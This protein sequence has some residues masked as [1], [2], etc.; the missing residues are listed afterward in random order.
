MT[1]VI[2]PTNPA[3]VVGPGLT[4]RL[5]TSLPGPLP[6]TTLWTV[7]MNTSGGS[8]GGV[9]L[10]SWTNPSTTIDWSLYIPQ[11]TK[12][13]APRI[14]VP[15]ADEIPISVN[16]NVQEGG[17]GPA[18]DTGTVDIP[19]S[20][21][22][23]VPNLIEH[24]AGAD[25]TPEEQAQLARADDQTNATFQNSAGQQT[26]VPVS[27]LVHIP[28]LQQLVI[29]ATTHDLI[30]SGSLLVP[31][32]GGIALAY[33][34]Q[35]V[36]TGVPAGIGRFVGFV[37]KFSRRV[38]QIVI[39]RQELVTGEFLYL[40]YIDLD[41]ATLAVLFDQFPPSDIGFFVEPGCAVQLRW[42]QLP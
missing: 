19:W 16:V 2:V 26:I 9:Y 27:S 25:L 21:T 6:G 39:A 37:D 34:F 22:L 35:L 29:Q 10:G 28:N 40:R 23:G 30:G 38:A 17:G 4:L 7:S 11:G 8:A 33:G 14:D 31:N 15:P 20:N 24:G 1:I 32:T 41:V 3:Q 18:Q 42:L 13:E 12:S 36:V 5:Q